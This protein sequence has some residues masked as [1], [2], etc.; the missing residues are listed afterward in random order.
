MSQLPQLNMDLNQE[1]S[2]YEDYLYPMLRDDA[3]FLVAFL[4]DAA[5]EGDQKLFLSS[6]RHILNAKNVNFSDL[7]RRLNIGRSTLYTIL[8]EKGNPS[9]FTISLILKAL[10]I[11]IEFKMQESA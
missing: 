8:S 2:Y 3:D 11:G 10:G 5:E 9:F 6:L 4:N 7:A 1:S